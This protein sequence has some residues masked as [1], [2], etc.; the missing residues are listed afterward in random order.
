MPSISRRKVLSLGV[1]AG[2]GALLPRHLAAA[3]LQ[4]RLFWDSLADPAAQ[5][6]TLTASNLIAVAPVSDPSS[7]VVLENLFPGLLSDS[8]FQ[9][10]RPVAFLV[11][12]VSNKDIRAFSSHWR[13]T[14]TSHQFE[15]AI[16]H[17]FHPHA[18][19]ES[20]NKN[21]S[22]PLFF[23]GD[24]PAIRAGATRLVT[25]FFS[26]SPS[27]YEDSGTPNWTQL[28]RRRPA[29]VLSQLAE[30][31]CS[32]TMLID[33]A[34]TKDFASVGPNDE[35]LAGFFCVT[36]NAEHDEAIS[37]LRLIAAG[38]SRERLRDQLGRDAL[39]FLYDV[40]PSRSSRY[41]TA[42]CKV[43]QRQAT[44]LLRR[45]R[46]PWDKF[47]KTLEYLRSQPKTQIRTLGST[48]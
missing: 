28:V 46:M 3:V 37:V 41:Y 17:Y 43:R 25:P 8:G 18:R 1:A 6:G 15:L 39:R 44:V 38:A 4:R 5:P 24:I 29:V 31:G 22:R 23:T 27:A 45:L 11:S 35:D 42:Y 26:W 19:Q 16:M 13:V 36:R 12:N 9:Q 47:L 14:T 20:T 48:A 21:E 30:P 10:F 7:E 2:A 34:I 40:P 32:V 33:G